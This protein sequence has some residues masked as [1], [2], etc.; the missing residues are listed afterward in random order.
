MHRLLTPASGVDAILPFP[1][2]EYPG[3]DHGSRLAKFTVAPQLLIQQPPLTVRSRGQ[4]A[5]DI[6]PDARA[7]RAGITECLGD[8]VHWVPM[9][10]SCRSLARIR[11]R[12]ECGGSQRMP[13]LDPG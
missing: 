1:R 5:R 4:Q 13:E 3:R 8:E 2:P 11:I 10:R 6:G 7:G 12:T 9:V